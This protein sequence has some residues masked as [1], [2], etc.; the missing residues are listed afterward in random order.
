MIPAAGSGEEPVGR[1]AAAGEELTFRWG[2]P[3]RPEKREPQLGLKPDSS[4]P[5]AA[6]LASRV[7]GGVRFRR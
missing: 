4:L 5:L 7:P 6:A 3:T 1:K 2:G